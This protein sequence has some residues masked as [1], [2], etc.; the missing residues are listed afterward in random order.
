M[1]CVI[2]AA[3]CHTDGL[4]HLT[5]RADVP[6]DLAVSLDCE[7]TLFRREPRATAYRQLACQVDTQDGCQST[8]DNGCLYSR[9]AHEIMLVSN[10]PLPV[11]TAIRRQS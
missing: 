6:S 1:Q 2:V 9:P 3:H 5:Q 4:S 10:L 11:S 8:A 7:R